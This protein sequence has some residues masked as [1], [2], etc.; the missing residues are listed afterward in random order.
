MLGGRAGDPCVVFKN[1]R[2]RWVGA[3]ESNLEKISRCCARSVRW[4]C[5]STKPTRRRANAKAATAIAACRVVSIDAG[6]G[7]VGYPEPRAYRVGVRHVPP[8]LL[9]VDL[10]RQG[11]LDVHIPLFPPQTADEVRALFLAVAR[12]LKVPLTATDM[13]PIDD[14]VQLG[15]NEIE[16]ILVR[17]LRTFELHADPKPPLT[18]NPRGCARGGSSERAHEEARIHGHD[19]GERVHRFPLPAT[20]I[21]RSHARGHRGPHY[22]FA[23]VRLGR[24]EREVGAGRNSRCEPG[25]RRRG[26]ASFTL[27]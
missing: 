24:R 6:Q 12:K 14:R 10:K 25:A 20:A 9:E 17:A 13:P 1:F 15:G 22:S 18:Q 4:S 5:S 7:D 11:R 26:A 16:G 3:A 21:P 19:C 27:R 8:D 2:D 23:T